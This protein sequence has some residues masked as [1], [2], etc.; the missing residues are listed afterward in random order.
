[1]VLEK[2]QTLE[3]PASA[4]MHVHLRDGA[5]K[6]LVVPSIRAGGV[7]CVMVMPNLVPPITTVA[8]ALQHQA[9]LQALEPKVQFLMSLYLHPD[10][11]PAAPAEAA[12]TA[13]SNVKSYPAG[14]TTNSSAGVVDYSVF[15]PVFAAMESH[16]MILNLHGELPSTADASITVLSAEEKF[17][18]TLR[19]LHEAFPRLRIIL[20]HCTTVV[21]NAH[22]FC[23][24][25]AK[26]PTDRKALLSAAAAGGEKFFFGSDSAP[27]ALSAKEM[28]GKPAAGCFTQGEATQLVLE[29]FVGAVGKGLLKEEEV[30]VEGIEGFLGGYGR[31]FYGVEA[32]GEK[33][34][35][36]RG[37]SKVADMLRGEG[38]L[39][40]MPF[41]AGEETW[42]LEWKA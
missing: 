12:A 31:K 27:H 39:E 33:I 17:L 23:K 41:R 3:L 40:I 28:R 22:H 42:S 6:N 29:A 14:V 8:H 11:N 37:A 34:V 10:V 15:Y 19:T 38:D 9:S 1:M 25:V 20:E 18:P 36:K 21:G 13:S 16:N 5:T 35:L 2:L 26:L 30:T 24:P 7:N 32:N 4:D